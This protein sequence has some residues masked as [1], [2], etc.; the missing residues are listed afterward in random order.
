[1]PNINL[2][3]LNWNGYDDTAELLCSLQKV[4]SQNFNTLVVD[5]DSKGDDAEKLEINF[6]GFIKV[7][8]CQSNLGF[9]GGNNEG[10]KKALRENAD[11]ILL[12]NND[13]TVEPDFLESLLKVFEKDS[14][15]GIVVP[16]INYYN[17]PN[18][19][20]TEGGRISRLKGSGFAYSDKL[21]SEVEQSD[22]SVSFVSGCCMLIKKEVFLKVGMFD[23]NYFLY[24]EDTDFCLRT[25]RAGYKIYVNPRSKIFH[26]VN[27]STKSSY[28]TLPLYYTT[29]NRLYFAK[30]NF[31]NS[32]FL[33]VIYIFLSMI[34]KSVMWLLS[35]KLKNILAVQKA[36]SDFFSGG[37]GKTEHTLYSSQQNK[38]D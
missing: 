14:K 24:T 11:Y 23:E 2:I 12:I 20:W 36:F 6:K 8:R 7:L 34:L 9:A 1:M 3:I 26:K 37:M 30:K 32:Y 28:S 38:K 4:R 15:I 16:Q 13:T 29:R 19:I 18:K 27:S 25:I 22:K 31:R 17:Q 21:E 35:G 5:N 33:T 10:I